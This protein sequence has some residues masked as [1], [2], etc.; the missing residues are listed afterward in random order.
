MGHWLAQRHRQEL[1]TIGVFMH[2]GRAANNA[3]QVY[4]ITP[5]QRGSLEAIL[6]Q[7]GRKYLFLDLSRPRQNPATEW[8]FKPATAKYN[9][10]H[11]MTMILRAQYDGILFIHTVAPPSYLY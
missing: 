3:R 2:Q 9:G 1:Y 5:V 6:A 11:D 4:E 8:M 10:T 7:A